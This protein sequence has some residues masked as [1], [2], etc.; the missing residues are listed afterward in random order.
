MEVLVGR[1]LTLL[2]HFSQ[3]GR[4]SFEDFFHVKKKK[5]WVKFGLGATLS[6][7]FRLRAFI[8][9]ERETNF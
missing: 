8:N 4:V 3:S 7:V 6:L 2:V 5:K 1:N 9:V